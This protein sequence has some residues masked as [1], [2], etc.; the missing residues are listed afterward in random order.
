MPD[1][2]LTCEIVIL[3]ILLLI[4]KE[5]YVEVPYVQHISL[6]PMWGLILLTMH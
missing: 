1:L 3:I 4:Y 2:L 6:Q 5:L